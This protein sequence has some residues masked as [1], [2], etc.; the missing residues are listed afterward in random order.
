M[1]ATTGNV[2]PIFQKAPKLDVLELTD[3]DTTAVTTL[4]TPGADG[5]LIDNIAVTSD[6]TAAIILE[7]FINDGVDDIQ[8]G[9]VTIPAGSGTDG[10]LPAINLLDATALPFL[11]AAGGLPLAAT[12][13]LRVACKTTMTAAKVCHLVA[14]GGDY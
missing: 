1:G 6:D 14:F 2:Q 4:V 3:A 12:Y 13:L 7:V 11:Q 8:I 9:E 10:A 5:A